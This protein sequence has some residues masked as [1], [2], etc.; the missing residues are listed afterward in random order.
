MKANKKLK[1]NTKK[2]VILSNDQQNAVQGG[3]GTMPSIKNICVY[4]ELCVA[5]VKNP[6]IPATEYNS[7]RCPE[8]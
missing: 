6:C 1:L 8:M 4:T 5:S 7:C 2:V 3:G